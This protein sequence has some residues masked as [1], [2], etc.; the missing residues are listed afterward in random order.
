M[1]ANHSHRKAP[2][3]LVDLVPRLDAASYFVPG[4]PCATGCASTC[5]PWEHASQWQEIKTYGPKKV[6]LIAEISK[7]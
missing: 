6:R 1:M 7:D 2:V 4:E 5:L 3:A